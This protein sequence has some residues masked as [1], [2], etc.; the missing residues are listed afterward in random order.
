MTSVLLRVLTIEGILF[1]GINLHLTPHHCVARESLMEIPVL[2][3][4]IRLGNNV[5]VGKENQ[6]SPRLSDPAIAST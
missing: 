5:G 3:Q 6:V 1:Q 4:Q 2:L